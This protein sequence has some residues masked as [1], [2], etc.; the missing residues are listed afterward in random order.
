MRCSR[1]FSPL[2]KGWIELD[3]RWQ[4]GPAKEYRERAF[5]GAGEDGRL[6]CFSFTSDGKRSVGHLAD[7]SD[8]AGEIIAF[9]ALMPAG[10]ARILY[11]PLN[12]SR[13]GFHFAVESKTQKGWNRFLE[14]KFVPQS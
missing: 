12:D 2:G 14:Q 5:F 1:T 9:E 7:A 10:L 8:V 6:A 3:A 13:P 4:I 11:W